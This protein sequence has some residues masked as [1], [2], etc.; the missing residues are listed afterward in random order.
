MQ[1]SRRTAQTGATENQPA[2]LIDLLTQ[3]QSL[4]EKLTIL[5]EQQRS[6]V[7]TGD[8]ENLLG[9]LAARQKV[10]DQLTKLNQ[11]ITPYR[12]NWASVQQQLSADQRSKVQVLVAEVE[13][14]LAAIIERDEQDRGSLAT[15]RD[16]VS[17]ELNHAG[18]AVAAINAYRPK[19]SSVAARYTNQQG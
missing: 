11:A 16:R 4:Y 13:K 19:P 9:V 8:A 10:I 6:M 3:Q 18:K 1:G 14:M 12:E 7:E 5:S 2:G 17:G 15:A